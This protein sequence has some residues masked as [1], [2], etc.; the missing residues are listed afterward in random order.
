MK[1]RELFAARSRRR[2]K[3]QEPRNTKYRQDEKVS[4]GR[5]ERGE[6]KG[7]NRIFPE[8][9]SIIKRC[10]RCWELAPLAEELLALIPAFSPRGE[11]ADSPLL[12]RLNESIRFMAPAFKKPERRRSSTRRRGDAE[13]KGNYEG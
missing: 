5:G 2:R 1:N 9:D 7:T 12:V 4:R 6:K 13:R 3:N 11:G 10:G 8:N